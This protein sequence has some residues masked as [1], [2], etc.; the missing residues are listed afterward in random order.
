MECWQYSSYCRLSS[1]CLLFLSLDALFS[2]SKGNT[3]DDVMRHLALGGDFLARGQLQ[4]ALHQFHSAV[5]G[6]P[7]NYL[8]YFKRG[9]VYFALGK[10]KLA[11][12]DF[13]KVLELKPDFTGARNQRA[14]IL[15]KQGN[16]EE[17]KADFLHI[18]CPWSSYLRELRSQ[19]YVALNDPLSAILDLR[20]TTKLQSD[21]TDGFYKL[22]IL[23]YQLGQAH[24]SLKEVRDC[25]KLD[26]DHKDCFP[27]YK[28]VKKVDKFLNDAQAATEKEDYAACVDSLSKILKTETKVPM[29][30]YLAFSK[31]CVCQGK[32]GQ[33]SEAIESCNAGLEISRDPEL[34]CDR[35]EV[36]LTME[37]YDEAM[38]DYHEVL[39]HNEGYGRAKEGLQR[40]QRLLKQS[41][42]RDYYKILGVKRSATKREIVK[43]YRK[44][45][46]QWHPDNFQDG[47]EKKKAEKKFIDI[48][49]AKEV[50]TNEEKRA[51]FDAGE[52]PL[53][54]ESGQHQGFN[55]F[56]QFRNFQSDGPFTYRFYFN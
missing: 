27:H 43:A 39:D 42:K 23:H 9:T 45:A 13:N 17:A 41:E 47:P 1:A 38:R 20:S 50:L 51:K 52:D 22:S 18:V 36:Y 49:A 2:V 44:A 6:D 14:H 16:L 33:E 12:I 53:D 40:A 32:N 29:I 24:E 48:A 35:A 54:P 26:P 21:N 30:R 56:Q 46:Q 25:L 34:L 3:Q 37:M 31:L 11:V 7:S 5:E 8:T 4:D 15:L 10:A 28:K 55:P 19:C